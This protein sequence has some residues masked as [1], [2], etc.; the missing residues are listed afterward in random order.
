MW[1]IGNLIWMYIFFPEI[2][3]NKPNR[4]QKHL[5]FCFFKRHELSQNYTEIFGQTEVLVENSFISTWQ[6]TVKKCTTR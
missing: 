4:V 5:F 2:E 1:G 3:K 6:D